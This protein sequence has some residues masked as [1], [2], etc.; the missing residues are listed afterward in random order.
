MK[1]RLDS[2][3]DYFLDLDQSLSGRQ[4]CKQQEGA[5]EF[6]YLC[7]KWSTIERKSGS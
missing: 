4:P 7:K 5:F 1:K 3:M 6:Q 2:L